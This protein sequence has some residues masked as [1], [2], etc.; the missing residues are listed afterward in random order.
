[1]VLAMRNVA[2]AGGR[3][4]SQRSMCGCERGGMYSFDSISEAITLFGT[5][6]EN[7]QA[8]RNLRMSSGD[9]EV[10]DLIERHLVKPKEESPLEASR[11]LTSTRREAISL[12]RQVLRTSRLFVWRNEQGVVWRDLIRSSARQEFEAARFEQDPELIARLLVG[13]RDAV[14]AAVD[15]FLK[16]REDIIKKEDD[17]LRGG[18]PTM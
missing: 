4:V 17:G 12:Y 2:I 18:R 14:Q 8:R 9:G 7:W 5:R 3:S 13:G 15:K 6:F 11:R 1:M 16:K 10:A